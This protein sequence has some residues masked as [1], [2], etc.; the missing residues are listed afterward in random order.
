MESAS[1][2]GPAWPIGFQGIAS[3]VASLIYSTRSNV[4]A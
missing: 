4:K 3:P 1:V 2:Q